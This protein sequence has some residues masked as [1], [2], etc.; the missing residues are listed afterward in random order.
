MIVSASEIDFFS[1]F[2][3]F[4]LGSGIGLIDI[5]KHMESSR[6]EEKNESIRMI[7]L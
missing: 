5:H 6:T 7:F 4:K 3:Q 1:E 2:E